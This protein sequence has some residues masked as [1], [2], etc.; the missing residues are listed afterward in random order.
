MCRYEDNI[1]NCTVI[2]ANSIKKYSNLIV[3][4]LK[5]YFK[6]RKYILL[7]KILKDNFIYIYTFNYKIHAYNKDFLLSEVPVP[8]PGTV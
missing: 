3:Q 2:F 4:F 8:A 5:L 1:L 7:L 6:S